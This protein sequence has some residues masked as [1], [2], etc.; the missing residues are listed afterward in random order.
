MVCSSTR[1]TST[2]HPSEAFLDDLTHAPV[3]LVAAGERLVEFHFADD[4]AQRRARQ[5]LDGVREVLHRVRGLLRIGDAVIEHRVDVDGDVV[6]GDDRLAGEVQHLFAQVDA[7]GG[8]GD[9]APFAADVAR[10]VVHMDMA[11]HLDERNEDV[12]A[13]AGNAV[14]PAEALDEEHLRLANDLQGLRA[15]EDGNDGDDAEDN[16]HGKADS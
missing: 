2:P 14:K 6:L 13:G 16:P 7:A 5:G 10:E 15:D 12:E 9:D 11:R 8:A 4:V 3:D 1:V